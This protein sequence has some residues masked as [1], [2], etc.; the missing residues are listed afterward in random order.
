MEVGKHFINET[1]TCLKRHSVLLAW[2]LDREMRRQSIYTKQDLRAKVFLPPTVSTSKLFTCLW[3]DLV[4]LLTLI[5]DICLRSQ[6]T[7]KIQGPRFQRN[8]IIARDQKSDLHGTSC[9]S[10]PKINCILI[11]RTI[12]IQWKF[13]TPNHRRFSKRFLYFFQLVSVHLSQ[14]NQC[15][16]AIEFMDRHVSEKL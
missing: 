15:F 4:R 13:T 12:C 2:R 5:T 11:T 3:I 10:S 7:K 8:D 14:S 9:Q 1:R 6:A 16:E